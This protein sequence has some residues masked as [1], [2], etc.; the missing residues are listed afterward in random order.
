M[1]NILRKNKKNLSNVEIEKKFLK[2]ISK[3]GIVAM[4]IYNK[5]HKNIVNIMN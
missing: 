2:N 5:T 1:G 3:S 4:Y